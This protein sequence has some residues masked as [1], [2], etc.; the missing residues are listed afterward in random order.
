VHF[1]P[2]YSAQHRTRGFTLIELLVVVAVIALLTALAIPSLAG[3]RNRSAQLKESA[4]MR[5]AMTAWNQYASD[6]KGWLIPAFYGNPPLE[7]LPAFY[8]DGKPIPPDVYGSQRAVVCRWPWRLAPYLGHDFRSL[9][10][11]SGDDPVQLASEGNLGKY[12]YFS[13]LYP[14]FGMNGMWVGGD[15][16][17]YGFLPAEISGQRNPLANFYASRLSTIRHPDRLAVFVSSRTNQSATATDACR[18]GYFR[19]ESPNWIGPQWSAY[20]PTVAAS[21]GNVSARWSG[22]ASVAN[23]DCSVEFVPIDE[24]RD[25]RRWADRATDFNWKF[26]PQ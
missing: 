3:V 1:S 7:T 20:D 11:Q 9:A 5:S 12:L 2:S 4:A 21:C 22:A 25:M 15:Q 14:A 17:R 23:V 24:L 26:S 10:M 6:Q 18:E 19:V 13:S 8:E 16:E